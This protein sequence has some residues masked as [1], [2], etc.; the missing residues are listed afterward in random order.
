MMSELQASP[1][2]LAGCSGCPVHA[3]L[4]IFQKNTVNRF[5]KT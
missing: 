4:G 2:I 3:D 1:A 5:L